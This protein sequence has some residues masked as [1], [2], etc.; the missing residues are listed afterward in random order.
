MIFQGF[1]LFVIFDL[2]K[3]SVNDKFI[4]EIPMCWIDTG[5]N[6]HSGLTR[7]GFVDLT[8]TLLD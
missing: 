5:D 1:G 3:P 6:W 7:L 8:V 2:C 4:D